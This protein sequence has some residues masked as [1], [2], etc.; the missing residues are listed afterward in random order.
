MHKST[1]ICPEICP[2]SPES[3]RRTR[4]LLLRHRSDVVGVHRRQSVSPPHIGLQHLLTSVLLS[5]CFCAMKDCKP[6]G[7]GR[8]ETVSIVKMRSARECLLKY[9]G[10]LECPV[11]L[12]ICTLIFSLQGSR[13]RWSSALPTTHPPKIRIS[14]KAF[15]VFYCCTTVGFDLPNTY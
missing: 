10:H 11:H 5:E 2:E 4:W 3:L 6:V 1:E 14:H 8:T 7:D 15:R 13:T 12:C 9:S